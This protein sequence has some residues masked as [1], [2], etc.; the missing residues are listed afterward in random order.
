[1]AGHGGVES[2]CGLTSHGIECMSQGFPSRRAQIPRSLLPPASL[3]TPHPTPHAEHAGRKESGQS[4]TFRSL[5]THTEQD[6]LRL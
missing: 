2:G 1:M 6:Q 5:P 4:H 3:S